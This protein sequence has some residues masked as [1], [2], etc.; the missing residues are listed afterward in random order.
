M[1]DYCGDATLED[2]L[3]E[4][5][6]CVPEVPAAVV[7]R[8][9]RYREDVERDINAWLDSDDGDG[10]P[11]SWRGWGRGFNAIPDEDTVF[12]QLVGSTR[13]AVIASLAETP[14]E[15][16]PAGY[17]RALAWLFHTGQLHRLD[18]ENSTDGYTA[19]S[20]AN[21]LARHN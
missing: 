9:E 1:S 18:N 21:R 14:F 11:L 15:S 12:N 20:L 13:Q 17:R 19:V 3:A 6:F 10:N 8:F 7:A 2:W 16:T 4:E 5:V